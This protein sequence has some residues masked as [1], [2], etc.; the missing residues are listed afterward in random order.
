MTDIY[1]QV[2][3][4]CSLK[5]VPRG[6]AGSSSWDLKELYATEQL[7]THSARLNDKEAASESKKL[8]L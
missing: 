8:L 6:L 4:V 1:L 5:V 3:K 2:T 7:G